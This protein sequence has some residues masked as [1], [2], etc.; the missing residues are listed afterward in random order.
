MRQIGT[1]HVALIVLRRSHEIVGLRGTRLLQER[2]IR[3]ISMKDECLW[4]FGRERE[5]FLGLPLD[6]GDLHVVFDE[7]LG[8]PAPDMASAGR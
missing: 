2:S 5:R 8:E 7:F 3:R 4:D 1:D 6:H